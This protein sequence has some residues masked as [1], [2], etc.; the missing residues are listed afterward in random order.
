MFFRGCTDASS[1]S[2]V[3]VDW[4]SVIKRLVR[5]SGKQHKTLRMQ[6]VTGRATKKEGRIRGGILANNQTG[7]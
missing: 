2:R 4:G 5:G 7:P 6:T 3:R 1:Q